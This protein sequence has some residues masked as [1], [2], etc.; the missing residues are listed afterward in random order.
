MPVKEFKEDYVQQNR[1]KPLM[2]KLR[3][4]TELFSN[5]YK[6]FLLV[7]G[8]NA[9][10]GLASLSKLRLSRKHNSTQ[11]IQKTK[12]RP[13]KI[14]NHQSDLKN[15][16]VR[17]PCYKSEPFACGAA[18]WNN[19]L[20]W[21][22]IHEFTLQHTTAPKAAFLSR[23]AVSKSCT[24]RQVFLEDKPKVSS[25]N[26]TMREEG[27]NSFS[28]SLLMGHIYLIQLFFLPP[29]AASQGF[30]GTPNPGWGGRSFHRAHPNPK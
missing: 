11:G 24:R 29:Q 6:K 15:W 2:S 23:S 16:L 30:T 28:N 9:S 26:S 8:R 12:Y 10:T 21:S 7:P 14:T 3:S 19:S 17:E 20:F 4:T 22:T 5:S 25:S 27:G 18:L 13:R 1:L